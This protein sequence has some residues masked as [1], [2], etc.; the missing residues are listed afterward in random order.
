MQTKK[1][2]TAMFLDDLIKPARNTIGVKMLRK[3][4]WREGTGIG[5]KIKRKLRKLKTKQNFGI[6]KFYL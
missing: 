2:F 5:P 3:M 4:G 6:F 1:N